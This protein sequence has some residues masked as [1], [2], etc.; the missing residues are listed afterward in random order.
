MSNLRLPTVEE[1]ESELTWENLH[2]KG[3]G[4]FARVYHVTIHFKDSRFSI[5]SVFDEEEVICLKKR[6]K[7]GLFT[8]HF[9][10]IDNV[11]Y[12]LRITDIQ[13][14]IITPFRREG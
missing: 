9:K 2:K 13:Q 10:D 11:E 12:F 8:K 1:S 3:L 14:I 7:Q 5:S 4:D 6:W